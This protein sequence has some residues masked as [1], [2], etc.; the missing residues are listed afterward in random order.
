MLAWNILYYRG[1]VNVANLW[2]TVSHKFANSG[3]WANLTKRNLQMKVDIR[4]IPPSFSLSLSCCL[5]HTHAHTAS[6]ASYVIGYLLTFQRQWPLD[7]V[8][9]AFLS[10]FMLRH[11]VTPNHSPLI[12]RDCVVWARMRQKQKDQLHKGTLSFW[13]S[14]AFFHISSPLL[15]QK[16]SHT[17]T[18]MCIFPPHPLWF[19]GQMWLSQVN[20]S[21]HRSLLSGGEGIVVADT[22]RACFPG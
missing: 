3:V 15:I 13:H 20:A 10:D 1:G 19:A 21:E 8:I 22:E 7:E 11:T 6:L 4:V 12:P 18:G 16:H 2:L 17:D 14:G 5:K 9:I